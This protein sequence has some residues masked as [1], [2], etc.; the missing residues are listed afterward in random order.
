MG[1]TCDS[2]EITVR[3]PA[4]PQDSPMLDIGHDDD[5]P[6]HR[7]WMADASPAN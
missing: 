7:A 6:V 5:C 2:V 3:V 4:N 1:C